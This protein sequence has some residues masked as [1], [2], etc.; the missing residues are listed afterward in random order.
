MKIVFPDSVESNGIG[1]L[2]DENTI[3][4]KKVDILST[5]K[6][7]INFENNDT[8]FNIDKDGLTTNKPIIQNVNNKETVML[9]SNIFTNIPID[10]NIFNVGI[11]S[12]ILNSSNFASL[13]VCVGNILYSNITENAYNN[14]ALGS[15]ART[16]G[17]NTICIGI[18]TG[19]NF[20]DVNVYNN[21]IC[22]ETNVN[23]T[24]S[25]QI[26]LGNNTHTTYIQKFVIGNE[27]VV[28][29]YTM[30]QS[31]L[32]FLVGITAAVQ[33][34]FNAIT[35]TLNTINTSINSITT[36]LNTIN[37][38]LNNLEN[39]TGRHVQTSLFGSPDNNLITNI[40][41]DRTKNITIWSHLFRTKVNSSTLY[42]TFDCKYAVNGSGGDSINSY[43]EI[44]DGDTNILIAVKKANFGD[45]NNIRNSNIILFPIHGKFKTNKP[46]GTNFRTNIVVNL[47]ATDDTL[48]IDSNYWNFK[49]TEFQY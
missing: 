22:I 45:T 38:R 25:N 46:S 29:I 4:K 42:I 30:T 20:N 49:V 40:I 24:D 8:S 16:Y 35:T 13:A 48:T 1:Y 39:Y 19:N 12:N 33:S 7:L 32:G 18:S 41:S 21:C 2:F 11:G 23:M 47:G 34:Q 6:L 9:G 37:T 27:L 5:D 15:Y 44:Y 14:I 31:I 17:N 36:T 28:G 26:R 43:I 10:D 3:L